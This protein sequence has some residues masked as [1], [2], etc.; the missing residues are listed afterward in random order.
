MSASALVRFRATSNAFAANSTTTSSAC[1]S[2]VD[3][4]SAPTGTSCALVRAKTG[5]R[6][7]SRAATSRTSAAIRVQDRYAPSTAT[8]SEIPTNTAPHGPTTASS[9]PATD[10]C[11]SA[12]IIARQDAERHDR[13][14]GED[15]EHAQIPQHR[16]PPDVAPAA[17][18]P[19]V[20]AGALHAD[21]GEHRHRRAAHLVEQ[22]QTH[23][24]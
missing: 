12:A 21:E 4:V 3:I 22:R 8:M 14:G 1:T 20:R 18:M 7:P 24:R 16:R 19:G 11:G 10:G 5:G 15:R 9:T 17:R 2:S 23:R 6:S 13:D